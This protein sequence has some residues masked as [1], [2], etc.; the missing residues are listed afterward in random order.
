MS[1]SSKYFTEVTGDKIEVKI[2]TYNNKPEG[3]G[4]VMDIFDL[5]SS[6]I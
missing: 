4:D 5:W 2:T 3:E 1:F 6:A